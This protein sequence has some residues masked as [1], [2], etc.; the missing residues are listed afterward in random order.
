MVG[1]EASHVTRAVTAWSGTLAICQQ[2]NQQQSHEK[3]QE[4]QCMNGA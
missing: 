2:K 4:K 3:K 1:V